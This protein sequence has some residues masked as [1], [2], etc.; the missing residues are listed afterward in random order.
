MK[1]IVS[2]SRYACGVRKRETVRVKLAGACDRDVIR[3]KEMI[4]FSA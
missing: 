1:G 2:V 3:H 4:P